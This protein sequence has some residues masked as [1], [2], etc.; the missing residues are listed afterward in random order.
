MQ[1]DHSQH[2]HVHNSV[3]Y[4]LHFKSHLCGKVRHVHRHLAN[5]KVHIVP[6]ALD[7]YSYPATLTPQQLHDGE[8]SEGLDI[9]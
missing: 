7:I 3:D 8:E 1:V 4:S 9:V 5:H 2:M 6:W